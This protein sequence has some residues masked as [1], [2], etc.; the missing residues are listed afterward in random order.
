MQYSWQEYIYTKCQ[1]INRKPPSSASPEEPPVKHSRL[2]SH[3]VHNY[4]SVSTKIEDEESY[5]RILDLLATEQRESNSS[6]TKIYELMRRKILP[7][8]QVDP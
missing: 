2:E 4:P 8:P 7:M 3:A 6:T 5:K 1:N